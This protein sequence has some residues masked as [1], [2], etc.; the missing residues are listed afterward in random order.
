MALWEAGWRRP[1]S[2]GAALGLSESCSGACIPP[3]FWGDFCTF[4]LTADLEH[5]TAVWGGIPPKLSPKSPPQPC[6][7]P[8]PALITAPCPADGAGTPHSA[9][10]SLHP[11]VR[12]CGK[13][14]Q[15]RGRGCVCPRSGLCATH[16]YLLC[17]FLQAGNAGSVE[18]GVRWWRLIEIQVAKEIRGNKV[19]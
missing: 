11:T 14:T 2:D 16:K 3:L 18:G 6:Q 17:K 9:W 13:G 8:D 1:R 19:K 12:G 5:S 7:Y 10:C 15:A 4:H